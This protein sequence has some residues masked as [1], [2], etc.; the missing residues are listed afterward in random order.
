VA[1]AF[2]ALKDAFKQ[3]VQCRTPYDNVAASDVLNTIL[4]AINKEGTAQ[5]S[6]LSDATELIDPFP[7]AARLTRRELQDLAHEFGQRIRKAGIALIVS[8]KPDNE[9]KVQLDVG[10]WP[11]GPHCRPL[12]WHYRVANHRRPDMDQ[13]TTSQKS[14]LELYDGFLLY[15]DEAKFR[16]WMNQ[17]FSPQEPDTDKVSSQGAAASSERLSPYEAEEIYMKYVAEYPSDRQPPSCDDDLAYVRKF[18][19]VSRNLIRKLRREHAHTT[20][21]E[22]GSPK[23]Y[24]A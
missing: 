3:W 24:R 10:V 16:S 4:E 9:S 2:I 1:E 6:T 12:A 23:K 14:P 17:T 15:L 18:G 22:G 11:E 19:F 5:N 8:E 7:N 21:S 13:R 20:W